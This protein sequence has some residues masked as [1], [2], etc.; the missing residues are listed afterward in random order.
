MTK[1]P[2]KDRHYTHESSFRCPQY[3]NSTELS[4]KVWELKENNINFSIKWKILKKAK[5]FSAGSKRCDLCLTEKHLIIT[6]K[7]KN[8][9]NSRNELISKCRHMNVHMLRK[10]F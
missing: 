4:K 1:G 10:V 9:L 5:A 2:F 8:L 7:L 6:S 3:K